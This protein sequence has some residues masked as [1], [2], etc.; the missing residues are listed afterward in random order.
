M[1]N[2]HINAWAQS[3]IPLIFGILFSTIILIP[4]F[5]I[6]G[7]DM[8]NPMNLL[9]VSF[10]EPFLLG[11]GTLIFI[12]FISN[13]NRF[14]INYFNLIHTQ[15][16]PLKRMFVWIIISIVGLLA[17]NMILS[18]IF[19]LADLEMAENVI[20]QIAEENPIY[21]LY[22]IPIML[23]AVGPVEEFIFRGVLQG[24]LR[25]AYGINISL[26]VTSLIFGLIHIPAAG[27]L[28][29]PALLY[30]ITTFVLGLLLGYI[31]EEQKSIII[32][33]VAHGVYN[34]IL[35][36]GYYVYIIDMI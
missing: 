13:S 8:D 14:N 1:K 36:V 3:L 35:L 17:F 28:H 27:G 20:F 30:V 26:F 31:Y 12:Y 11:I 23:L 15:K 21:I 16:I 18:M 5:I 9:L 24:V 19:T 33:I 32:P 29:A 6:Y 22:L 34:S 2:K 25:D 7:L 4:I 10:F